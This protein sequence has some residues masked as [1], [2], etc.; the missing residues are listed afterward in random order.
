[1]S[2]QADSKAQP[3]APQSKPVQE[4][5]DAILEYMFN[6]GLQGIPIAGGNSVGDDELKP[7]GLSV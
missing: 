3:S 1:M 4:M 5:D 6:P 2:N 7:G